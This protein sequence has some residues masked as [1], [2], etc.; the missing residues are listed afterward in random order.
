MADGYEDF[1][2]NCGAPT[3]LLEGDSMTNMCESCGHPVEPDDE[4]L[5]HDDPYVF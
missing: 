4:S 3:D 1:C 5:D 2:G